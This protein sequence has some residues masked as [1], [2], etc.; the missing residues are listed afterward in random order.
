MKVYFSGNLSLYPQWRRR[1]DEIL[2]ILGQ[3]G[4]LVVSNLQPESPQ[5]IFKQDLQQV[6][7]S[8][9]VLLEKVDAIIIEG[10]HPT[11]E[12]GHLIALALTHQKSVLYLVEKGFSIDKNLVRLQKDRKVGG[13]LLLE[14][15]TAQSLE[16]KIL[17][18]LQIVEMGVNRDLPNIKFTLRITQKIERYLRWKAKKSKLTKADFLRA[19]I[20]EMIEGD[21]GFKKY[22]DRG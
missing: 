7:Q 11:F 16:R 2:R 22:V 9:E 19:K 20:E 8:G 14:N 5:E 17:D 3:A 15:Y 18:F 13:L 6:E 12:N 4:V 21:E 1:L 10:T